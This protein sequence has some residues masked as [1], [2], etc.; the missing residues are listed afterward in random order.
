MRPSRPLRELRDCQL[1]LRTG[2]P[3]QGW[4]WWS[5]S[6][7]KTM[8]EAKSSR[9]LRNMIISHNFV[10]IMWYFVT[11]NMCI[12]YICVCVHSLIL[13]KMTIY[14]LSGRFRWMGT[15]NSMS[16]GPDHHRPICKVQVKVSNHYS[17]PMV[18]WSSNVAMGNPF[19][20]ESSINGGFSRFF[21][22]AMFDYRRVIQF[23][24]AK[25]REH[26]L[27]GSALSGICSRH[28]VSS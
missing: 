10:I 23:W 2:S 28:L 5:P 26:E 17:Y 22:H 6:P 12:I 4:H 16:I 25:W 14:H 9:I 19:S 15:I 1:Y 24:S 11:A 18:L 13:L 20:M 27:L 7:W 3:Q 21:Q 8:K